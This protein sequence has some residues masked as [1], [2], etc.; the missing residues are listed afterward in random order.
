MN[1]AA[2]SFTG[3]RPEGRGRPESERERLAAGPDVS[4]VLETVED[5]RS[6][7]QL[8]AGTAAGWRGE[9]R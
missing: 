1:N 2:L 7:N 8:G 6:R 4:S 9:R 5:G 3:M